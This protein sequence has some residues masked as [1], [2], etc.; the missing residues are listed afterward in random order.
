MEFYT[1]LWLREDGTKT[2]PRS[3]E[4][5]R[6][7]SQANTGKRAS[8]ETRRKQ[9]E[10]AKRRFQSPEQ[11]LKASTAGKLGAAARWGARE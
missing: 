4:H 1:Y 3:V 9:S 2:V 8:E 7:L 5:R 11:R 10:S 6:H